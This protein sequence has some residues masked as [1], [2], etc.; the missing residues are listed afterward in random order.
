MLP[1]VVESSDHGGGLPGQKSSTITLRT[2]PYREEGIRAVN[3]V[4]D[5]LGSLEDFLTESSICLD[6]RAIPSSTS[7]GGATSS[8]RPRAV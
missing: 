4:L 2:Y 1:Q 7:S 3:G 5:R 6:P 8:V